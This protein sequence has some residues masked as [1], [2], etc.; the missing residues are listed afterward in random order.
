MLRAFSSYPPERVL[1]LVTDL[2][3]AFRKTV[4]EIGLVM[5]IAVPASTVS[6]PAIVSA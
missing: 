2:V 4:S 6:W 3:S 1:V 5:I